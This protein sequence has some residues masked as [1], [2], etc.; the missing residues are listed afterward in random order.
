MCSF[1]YSHR[2]E[3]MKQELIKHL[4]PLQRTG[5]VAEWHDRRIEPGAD[6]EREINLHLNRSHIILLLISADFIYSD[7]CYG[8]EMIRALER[9][10]LGEARVVPVILRP[11]DWHAL[12]FGKLQGLPQDGKPV[13][14]WSNQDE[15][16]TDI[17]RGI[18]TVLE[19]DR[20]KGATREVKEPAQA[21][22]NDLIYE[23]GFD[24]LPASPLD[25]GKGWK[26]A[27]GSGT[28]SFRTDPDFPG[29]LVM[30]VTNG[31]FAMDHRVPPHATLC[32]RLELTIKYTQ[33]TMIFTGIDVTSRDGSQRKKVWIK[34][35]PG[36]RP[37]EQTKDAPHDPSTQLP[38]QTV[39]IT[40]ELLHNGW[41]AFAIALPET[42]T[43]ALGAQGW[44]YNSLWAIRL[45]GLLSISP[46]RAL[47]EAPRRS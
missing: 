22:S 37:P 45:R 7:Y 29:S 6:W 15:A 39:W 21:R 23:I 36:N 25:D 9:E 26:R 8:V 10:A 35:Y 2:D 41:M 32:D 43:R 42:V 46:I 40:P 20:A 17:V 33:S 30:D 1:A 3:Q 16:Y 4:S 12:P 19:A 14:T 11:C 34:Y 28:P 5:L 47:K 18:R 38:E 44:V 31:E 13:T 24:Y 27:Y